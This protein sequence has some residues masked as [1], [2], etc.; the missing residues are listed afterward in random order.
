MR[1]VAEKPHDAVVKFDTYLNVQRHRAVLTA[2]ARLLFFLHNITY[3]ITKLR[4][5]HLGSWI[6][7][8]AIVHPSAGASR[9]QLAGRGD[10]AQ[11]AVVYCCQQYDWLK[12]NL[13][14]PLDR[15]ACSRS[16]TEGRPTSPSHSRLYI[17]LGNKDEPKD[18]LKVETRFKTDVPLKKTITD[19]E[20][21]SQGDSGIICF[22]KLLHCWQFSEYKNVVFGKRRLA[23]E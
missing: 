12:V 16:D 22:L 11:A 9:S 18:Q 2:I 7:V 3:N 13:C 21:L 1:A 5:I 8:S 4:P 17:F 20:L 10:C 23:L 15:V 6:V 14:G 19:F